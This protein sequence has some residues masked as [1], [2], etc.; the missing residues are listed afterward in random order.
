MTYS[1]AVFMPVS[2]NGSM[3]TV[4]TL[5]DLHLESGLSQSVVVK[6]MAEY[7]GRRV[8]TQSALSRIFS[9]GTRQEGV[10]SALAH[11]YGLPRD[12][13]STAASNS[14]ALGIP[15]TKRRGSRKV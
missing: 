1:L 10:I 13:V 15:E 5:Y 12:R 4:E 11:A 3:E 8:R 14:C 6:K 2:H 7:D 9:R